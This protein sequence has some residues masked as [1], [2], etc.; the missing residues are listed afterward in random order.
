LQNHKTDPQWVKIAKHPRVVAIVQQLLQGTP[1]I[2]QSMYMAKASQGG[3][4]VA[5]HQDTHY[6]PNEPNTLMACWLAFND[7]DPD[8]GGLCVVPGSHKHGLR[9]TAK[10]N[11]ETDHTSWEKD[12]TMRDRTGKCWDQ[13]FYSF[14]IEG[15]DPNAIQHLSIPCGAGVFFTSITIHGSFA[16]QSAQ[17]QRLAFATHYVRQETW[18]FRQDVQETVPAI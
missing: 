6:L 16:N 5:P 10:T 8:N 13:T 3:T 15:L 2:V 11:N 1:Y 12:Y 7:T 4:G 17:R 18:L 14:Q 9:S